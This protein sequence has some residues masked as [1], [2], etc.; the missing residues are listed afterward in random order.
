[1]KLGDNRIITLPNKPLR[2]GTLIYIF[3]KNVKPN[4]ELVKLYY[5]IDERDKHYKSICNK[6]IFDRYV[7]I[8]K[9]ENSFVILPEKTLD[10]YSMEFKPLN[11]KG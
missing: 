8:T 7:F 3:K 1:M 9:Y 4:P 2:V 10:L 6:K 11:M 5:I